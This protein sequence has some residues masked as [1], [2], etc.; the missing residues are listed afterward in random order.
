M[1]V[2]YH[3]AWPDLLYELGEDPTVQMAHMWT[4]IKR[5][6]QSTLSQ[7]VWHQEKGDHTG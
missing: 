6:R 4:H 7:G 3:R 5:T 2:L 1:E